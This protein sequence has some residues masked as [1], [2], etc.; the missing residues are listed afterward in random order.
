VRPTAGTLVLYDPHRIEH[1]ESLAGAETV[2]VLFVPRAA[3]GL[4]IVAPGSNNFW[5]SR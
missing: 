1:R 2:D 3:G 4:Q 5:P